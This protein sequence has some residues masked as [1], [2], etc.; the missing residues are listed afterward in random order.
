MKPLGIIGVDPGTTAAY[1]ILDLNG[2]LIKINSNKEFSL[3]SVISEV[4]SVCQPIIVSTDKAKTPSFVSD[5]ATKLGCSLVHPPEDLKR[6][7]KRILI[8]EHHPNPN[9]TN[10]QY[11][12][13]K[14]NDYDNKNNI[15]DKNNDNN[16]HNTKNNRNQN[17][18]DDNDKDNEDNN[19][20][21][22]KLERLKGDDGHQNDS[23]AAAIFAYKKYSLRLE[24]INTYVQNNQLEEIKNEFI[25]IALKEDLH[26]SLIKSLLKEPLQE[27]KIIHDVLAEDKITKKDFL[28]LFQKLSQLKEEKNS[29][30]SRLKISDK[31]IKQ[32][33]NI[34][35]SLKKRT[36]HID[37]R[38]D[39]LLRFKEE[40]IKVQSKSIDE[41]LQFIS[42]LKEKEQEMDQFVVKADYLQLVKKIRN[43]GKLEF[44][45]K[46]KLL[47]VKDH[48][49]LLIENPSEFSEEAL[50]S[51]KDK[52]LILISNHN[53]PKRITESFQTVII[54]KEEFHSEKSHFALIDPK[55]LEVRI[56][57]QMK[58]KDFIE[59]IITEYRESR[60]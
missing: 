42:V 18:N 59:K 21:I 34:N 52:S 31:E 48:D 38:F 29:L 46:N 37:K 44:S 11:I 27:H 3:S 20:D 43:L 45:E 54:A 2:N 40:R 7:E 28:R 26:F 13:T 41:M 8:K 49:Y 57:Q 4:I 55:I 39:N 23:L 22:T 25:K 51:L 5:F 60:D 47:L 24:K 53:F 36:S 1:A 6:E 19:K 12:N 14:K 32:L 10:H 50:A 16:N 9:K 15:N 33:K 56:K 35:L 30:E 58:Q 17:N